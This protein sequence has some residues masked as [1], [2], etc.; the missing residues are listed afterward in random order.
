KILPKIKKTINEQLEAKVLTRS[1]NSSKTSY[2]VAADLSEMELKKILI[3]KIE[4]NKYIQ[5]SDEQRN[6]Y[7]ALIDAYEFEKFILDTYGDTTTLKRR[8]DDADKDEEPS[9][10]SDRGSKRR[11]EGKEPESTSAPKE[12]AT[13][14]TGKSN[15]GSKSHQKTASKSALTE[16]PMQT[17]QDLEEPSHQEFEIGAAGDQPIV[18]ASQHP[19][20]FQQQ[21]KP[22][23]PDLACKKT[24]PATYESIQPWISDLAKQDDS[25]SSF[26]ELMDTP[27]LVELKFFLEEVYKATTDQLDWNNPKG[28]QYPHNLLKPLPLIPNSRGRHIIPFDHFI[29]NDLEYLRGG[30]SS[31]K[32]T[33]SVTKNKAADYG[34]L[35]GLKTWKADKRDGRRTLCFQRLSKNVHKKHRHPTAYGRSSTRCQKL[36]KEAQP[37]KAKYGIRMKYLPQAIW[38]KS[39]KERAAAMIQAIDK[40]LKTRRIMRSLE[41][42]TIA[43]PRGDLKAITT[44]SGVSYDGPPIPPPF[45]SLSKVVER[46]PE[47]KP[48]IPYPSRVN[49]QKLREK[50]DNLALKF[51]EIFRKLHFDLSFA[52][53]LLH[54]PKFAIMFKSLLNNKEKL[55]DLA[56]LGASINLMPLSIWEKLNLPDLTPTRMILELADRST[57]RPTCIAEDGFVKV[58]KFHFLTDFIVVDYVVNPRVLL[59]LKRS[60]LR[61]RC[62]MAIFHDMIEETMDVFMD[63]FSV[64]G[65]SF[66]SCLSHLDKMLKRCKDANL[67]L[68]WEKCHF[69]VKEGIVLGHKISKFEI[70]IDKAKVDVIAKLSHLTSVKGAENLTAD[71]LSRLENP[72]QDELE[73][74]EITETFPLETFGMIAFRGDST[75][76]WFADIANYHVENFIVKGMSQ[77]AIDILTAYHNGPTG[78][79]NGA[80][81]TAKKSLIPVLIGRL[82]TEM[83][84]T[85]SHGMPLVNVKA[86]SR[87][88]MK[89]LKMQFKFTRFLTFEASTLWDHS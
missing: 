82:F 74:K 43:N 26:N 70:K 75:T 88:V 60:F 22:L 27:S 17:T 46:V 12:K 30:A 37:H 52:D 11:R 42:N 67:V 20:C 64:F 76:S 3:E 36:P 54:M 63:D 50:D 6:L 71:H 72:H 78:G 49:K 79:H 10:G 5:R 13:K 39:N 86:K 61:T 33:T 15:Q 25:R 16:E 81:F 23:T 84:M 53:A 87:N 68:N 80:N 24:L 89:C 57:T 48:T 73:K 77:E 1:S 85:W 34:T 47:P 14:T 29:N 8:H 58:G 66:S 31:R 9:A 21:K 45:S 69:M 19:E 59:I 56:D 40:Q 2:A 35:S 41:K 4:S 28:K 18:E 62:M 83:P 7:K 32:Y 55:F 38:R 44:R 65:D 51:V